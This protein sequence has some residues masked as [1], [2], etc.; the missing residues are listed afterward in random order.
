M[1]HDHELFKLY[2]NRGTVRPSI[3]KLLT[4]RGPGGTLGGLLGGIL[5]G[6]SGGRVSF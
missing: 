1:P 2:S 6:I 3:G 5:G 4:V